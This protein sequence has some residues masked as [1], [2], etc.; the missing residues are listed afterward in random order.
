MEEDFPYTHTVRI[1]EEDILFENT[2]KKEDDEEIP[3]TTSEVFHV[4]GIAN[5]V[6]TQY[7]VDTTGMIYAGCC[8]QRAKE[9][10]PG[11]HLQETSSVVIR[12]FVDAP[13]T[14]AVDK[15]IVTSTERIP[16]GE[17]YT[18]AISSMENLD[19]YLVSNGTVKHL[20]YKLQFT[21]VDGFFRKQEKCK[22]G[23]DYRWLMDQGMMSDLTIKL[24]EGKEHKAHL[25]VLALRCTIYRSDMMK[26][27]KTLD[28]SRY[29]LKAG[30]Q[31]SFYYS[32]SYHHKIVRR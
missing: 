27:A 18:V 2:K 7:W 32:S 6:W 13:G 1:L 4:P 29:S 5:E 30:Q 31:V 11:L 20:E 16:L 23:Q 22:L 8:M 19:S 15:V 3:A 24:A 21:F 14:K 17:S 26:T 28:W 25:L 12:L 9:N 10:E